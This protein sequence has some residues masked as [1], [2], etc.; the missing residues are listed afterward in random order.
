MHESL[1]CYER[2]QRRLSVSETSPSVGLQ[3]F[4]IEDVATGKLHLKLEWLS[5]LS[6]PEKLDQVH[7]AQLILIEQYTLPVKGFGTLPLF[8]QFLLKCKQF[9]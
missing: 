9:K 7:A 5:L 1:L 8:F 6:T 2:R 3:W 4:V